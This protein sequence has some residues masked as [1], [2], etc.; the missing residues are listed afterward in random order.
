MY[1]VHLLREVIHLRVIPPCVIMLN[2]FQSTGG[3]FNSS[4]V[5]VDAVLLQVIDDLEAELTEGY[6]LLLQLD[7]P[8]TDP[9]D[10]RRIKFLNDIVLV[11]IEDDG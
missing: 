3:D 1:S 9:R 5:R 6:I 8:N 11:A 4:T 10:V 7:V 2:C